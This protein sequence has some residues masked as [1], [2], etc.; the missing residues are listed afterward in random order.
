MLV[1][2]MVEV[3]FTGQWW[4]FL[5]EWTVVS[6]KREQHTTAAC[7]QLSAFTQLQLCS[8]TMYH[9]HT[10]NY[11]CCPPAGTVAPH[12]AAALSSN[13]SNRLA[14]HPQAHPA[15][16][17]SVSMAVVKSA[18]FSLRASTLHTVCNS[19]ET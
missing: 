4:V 5:T 13:I 14:R 6:A 18:S 16:L 11:S 19:L 8:Y 1:G 15:H 7:H 9:L 10:D 3:V 17:G 2:G 12:H